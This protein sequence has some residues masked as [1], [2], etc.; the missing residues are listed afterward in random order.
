LHQ[1]V[2]VLAITSERERIARE[3]HDS[4]SQVLAYV[5]TKSQ[6]AL[7]L[8]RPGRSTSSPGTDRTASPNARDAYVDV[9]EGSCVAQCGTSTTLKR[10]WRR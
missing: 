5:N 2:E 4:L 7:G 8:A 9:R 6:A 1:Q 3:M 10:Q